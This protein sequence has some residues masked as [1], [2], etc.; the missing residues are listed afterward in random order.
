MIDVI[1]R[2]GLRESV[3]AVGAFLKPALVERKA[4]GHY[5]IDAVR[6]IPKARS[7]TFADLA[8][9]LLDSLERQDLH[10]CHAY[11]AN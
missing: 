7:L 6:P 4:A 11:I 1:E 8:T 10:R 5:R 9:A 3:A 2:D